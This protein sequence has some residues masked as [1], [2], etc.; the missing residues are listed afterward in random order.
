MHRL[1]LRLTAVAVALTGAII[2]SGP[3]ALAATLPAAATPVVPVTS[4]VTVFGTSDTSTPWVPTQLPVSLPRRTASR[5]AF[6]SNGFVTVL[7]PRGWSCA[8]VEAAN[9]GRS[10]SV[11]A[12]GH[13]DPLAADRPGPDVACS[14]FPHT[15]AAA[16]ARSIV[17]CPTP[18]RR[19]ALE[20]PTPDVAIF[21][22]PPGV[23]GSGSP[24]G[25]HNAASGV[26]IFPQLNPEPSSVP[27]AKATCSLPPTVS[28]LCP[29]IIADFLT[30]FLPGPTTVAS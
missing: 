9:G 6:Y 25:T 21:R 20:R 11:F 1:P 12:P 8:G 18:P 26:A 10:L 3:L 23:P 13:A 16:L 30:R 7:G 14:L 17:E 15:R 28:G 2:G 22:D 27:V 19:E 24:S 4:C 29:A 5:V